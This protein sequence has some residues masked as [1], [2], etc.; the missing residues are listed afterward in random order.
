MKCF[1]NAC[2]PS[3]SHP[4]PDALMLCMLTDFLP[5]STSLTDGR[6]ALLSLQGQP[7]RLQ[8]HTQQNDC[9][10]DTTQ[11]TTVTA[12]PHAAQQQHLQHP[13]GAMTATATPHAPLPLPLTTTIP[14]ESGLFSFVV[15][16]NRWLLRPHHPPPCLASGIRKHHTTLRRS[17][18]L[19]TTW[20]GFLSS[21]SR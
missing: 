17:S 8:H 9:N 10:H 19:S 6:A 4:Q 14:R 15:Q 7:P 11:R 16:L 13:R 21:H 18:T 2:F 20:S 5:P 3:L 12:A 1:N